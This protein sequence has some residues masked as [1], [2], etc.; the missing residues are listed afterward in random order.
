[1]SIE[2]K[3]GAHNPR[4]H[5]EGETEKRCEEAAGKAGEQQVTGARGHQSRG[6]ELPSGHPLGRG[7]GGGHTVAQRLLPT[8][9][10]AY[11]FPLER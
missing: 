4:Q 5:I 9:T 7:A 10:R 3:S 8:R 11:L 2:R 1:M 6:R